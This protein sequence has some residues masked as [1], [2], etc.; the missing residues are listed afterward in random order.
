VSTYFAKKSL[1][2]SKKIFSMA[3][4]RRLFLRAN[5]GVILRE[6]TSRSFSTQNA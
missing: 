3:D 6:Y 4:A 2:E 1:A 5:P